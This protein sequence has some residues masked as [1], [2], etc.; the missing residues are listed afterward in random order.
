MGLDMT[1]SCNLALLP[2]KERLAVQA[3]KLACRYR[4]RRKEKGKEW[5]QWVVEQMAK[6]TPE[7]AG[8]VR[9]RLNARGEGERAY[10]TR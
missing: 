10:R 5:R 6:L 3:D 2:A 9:E 8:A 7:M 1:G 4:H